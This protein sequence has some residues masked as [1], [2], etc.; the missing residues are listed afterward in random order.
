MDSFHVLV[1][2]VVVAVDDTVVALADTNYGYCLAETGDENDDDAV[3]DLGFDLDCVV[4]FVV[5]V[6]DLPSTFVSVS[7]VPSDCHCTPRVVG[8]DPS[9]LRMKTA[10]DVG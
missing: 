5:V 6:V 7:G 2:D 8:R 4:V 1:G 3:T 9:E 10:P